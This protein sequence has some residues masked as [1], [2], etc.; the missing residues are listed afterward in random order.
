MAEPQSRR[1]EARL[2]AFPELRRHAESCCADAG[3]ER[4]AIDRLVLVLEELFAN[5]VE[6]GYGA[7]AAPAERPVWLT[8][9]AAM[10]RV[11]VVYEDAGP[12]YDPFTRAAPPDYTGPV[13]SWQIGGLGV[14]LVIRLGRN[15]RYERLEGRNRI[16][17]TMLAVAPGA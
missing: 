15:V 9:A 12:E 6:H 3:F 7:A 4:P 16:R 8:I 17:F 14:A 2:E 10:G 13:D 1:F 5:T 11:E